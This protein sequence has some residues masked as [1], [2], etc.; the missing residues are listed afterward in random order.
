[1]NKRTRRW[2]AAVESHDRAKVLEQLQG[3]IPADLRRP[4]GR[5][6]LMTA[7]LVRHTGM[8]A[9]LLAHGADI[10]LEDNAGRNALHYLLVPVYIF[11]PA[12]ADEDLEATATLLLAAGAVPNR[13]CYRSLAL[14]HEPTMVATFLRLSGG[15][16]LTSSM[17]HEFRNEART[18]PHE[19]EVGYETL[20]ENFRLFGLHLAQSH[21]GG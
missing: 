4:D 15:R 12:F 21:K 11:L 14:Y 8:A 16:G 7:S 10:Y 6:A 9:L 1:M 2:F 19:V 3:G 13:A 20:A 18:R 5:T 17:L